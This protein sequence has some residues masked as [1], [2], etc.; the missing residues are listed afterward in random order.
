MSKLKDKKQQPPQHQKQQPG[1]ESKMNPQPEFISPTYKGSSKLKGK[2]ALITGG[3]SG[4]GRAVAIAFAMEG[5][6]IVVHYL[7]EHEDAEKTKELIES[8][9]Q[10]CWLIPKNLQT[11]KACEQLTNKALKVTKNINILVNNIAEQ[12]PKQSIEDISCE[13]L[14]QT[15]KTNF[16]SYFYMIK[17]LLP[18]FKKEQLLH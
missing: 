4:I 9:G 2:T 5:A 18:Q 12:H 6:D 16:F 3:D 1:K 13:Q 10:Q 7:N 11:Y 15:F 17:A 8:I 14:E